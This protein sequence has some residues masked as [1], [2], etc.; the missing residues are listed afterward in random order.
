LPFFDEKFVFVLFEVGE[1][2]CMICVSFVGYLMFN[3]RGSVGMKL[4]FRNTRCLPAVAHTKEFHCNPE[5]WGKGWN[6]LSQ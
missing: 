1:E 4:C 6:F 5:S 3:P 2:S